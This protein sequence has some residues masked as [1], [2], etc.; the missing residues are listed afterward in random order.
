MIENAQIVT[1]D[2]AV[3]VIVP[4]IRIVDKSIETEDSNG[5]WE[6]LRRNAIRRGPHTV[7]RPDIC[8]SESR[9][10]ALSN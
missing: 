1:L 9:F 6:H 7:V 3:G 2:E 5:D 8:R 4:A 10:T